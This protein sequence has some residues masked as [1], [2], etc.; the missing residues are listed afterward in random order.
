MIGLSVVDIKNFMAGMLTGNM[1]DKFLTASSAICPAKLRRSETGSGFTHI[2]SSQNS[3]RILYVQ[4]VIKY[5][6]GVL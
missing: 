6:P 3:I 5:I 2:G 4:I 1:F